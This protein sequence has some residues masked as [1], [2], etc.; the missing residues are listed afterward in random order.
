VKGWLAPQERGPQ[1]ARAAT[2]KDDVFLFP[3]AA[4][5][6]RPGVFREEALRAVYVDWKGGGQINFLKQL[7][8]EWW[9]RWQRVMAGGFDP[10]N[11]ERYRGL[12]IDYLVVERKNRLAG[13]PPAFENASFAVYSVSTL[14][15]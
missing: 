10:R 12:G 1:W 8:A 6:L 7:G 9:S 5:D 13:S 11:L 14:T 15:P 2:Q 3:D 4:E